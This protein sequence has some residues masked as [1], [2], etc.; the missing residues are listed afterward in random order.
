[1]PKIVVALG[2]NQSSDADPLQL[3]LGKAIISLRQRGAVIRKESRFYQ[4]PCFPKGAGPDYVNAAILIESAW[5]PQETL[6]HLHAVENEFGRKRVQRWGQ[7]TLDLDLISV[8]DLV[9][10]NMQTYELWR[11]LSPNLQKMRAPDDLILPHP[12]VQ[13]RA[14]VLV[15]MYDI[16]PDWLHPVSGLSITQLLDALSDAEKASVIPIK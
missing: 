14:F 2:C 3:T 9:A 8:D 11:D 13:D 4:T 12:R 16:V 6:E 10:P 5:S 15:P 7:R 1:M